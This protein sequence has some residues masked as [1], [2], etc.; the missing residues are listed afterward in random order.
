[1]DALLRRAL[2]RGLA[3]FI[4]VMVIGSSLVSAFGG[5]DE[6]SAEPTIAPTSP[7][8]TATPTPAT[9]RTWLAWVPGGLPQG[10]GD[11]VS[12]VT[13]VTASTT[14]TADIAWMTASLDVNGDAVDQP[15]A[16]WMIPLDVTG[17]DATFASFVPE[18]ER[19]LV[20]D[21]R[22]NEGIL[23]ESEAHLRG[24]S[25]GSTLLF[26]GGSEINIVGT[27]P[28]AL[29]G[30]YELL[31][32]RDT[33]EQLGVV[34]ERYA[35]FHV[36]SSGN[37]TADSLA[38]SFLD[39][40][41]TDAPYP[42]VETRAPG[43]AAY[44]RANDRVIPP[45][46]LKQTFGEF[47]ARPD[48]TDIGRISIDP[49]WIQ[50]NIRSATLPVLGTVTCDTQTIPLLKRAVHEITIAGLSDEI[51]DIGPCFEPVAS[52]TDPNGPL[53][54]AA[55]G[56]SIQLN[57]SSN[58]PGDK[59]TQPKEIIQ[60]MYGLGFGWAGNDAYPQGALFRYRKPPAAQD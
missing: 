59:P 18:P 34:H 22:P 52:P 21:L 53:P 31:V 42:A 10:F 12:T 2:L 43:E 1:M 3:T 50:D 30:A 49:T 24:L 28:D 41:P 26:R 45:L 37:P 56:V 13:D 40:L 4:I 46:V 54:P 32:T 8:S 58:P 36:R 57:P 51:V 29:M 38:P 11:L 7:T 9:P 60:E 20:Q 23:S 25:E 6:R 33:G 47:Q 44:L 39:L 14:A 27:L 5:D 55:W 17:V 16:P 19:Q 15:K 35:L 48:P